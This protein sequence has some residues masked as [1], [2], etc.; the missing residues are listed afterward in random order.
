MQSAA[1]DLDETRIQRLAALEEQERLRREADDRGRDRGGGDR[2]FVNS[3]HKK[4]SS[5]MV[6]G[7]RMR[8]KAGFV[9]EED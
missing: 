9:K 6:L 3:L 5:R 1:T 2:G 4:A 8:G 7:D